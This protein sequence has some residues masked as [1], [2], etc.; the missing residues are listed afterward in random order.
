MRTR[1]YL[2]ATLVSIHNLRFYIRLV[3][4]MRDAINAGAFAEFK[5]DFLGRYATKSQAG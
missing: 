4:R 1:E 3:D 2:G 5:R